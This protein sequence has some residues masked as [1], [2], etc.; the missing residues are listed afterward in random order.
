VSPSKAFIEE[1][2]STLKF[3][4]RAKL[5]RVTPKV[6]EVQD[7]S[8]LIRKLEHELAEARRQLEELAKGAKDF[9]MSS[10]G[11]PPETWQAPTAETDQPG[12]DGD[13]DYGYEDMDAPPKQYVM[14]K[15][16]LVPEENPFIGGGQ[17]NRAYVMPKDPQFR[18]DIPFVAPA[19]PSGPKDRAYVMPKNQSVLPINNNRQ[20]RRGVGKDERFL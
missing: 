8:A 2:R 1:T 13:V 15:D 10:A 19:L 6:N 3:A 17:G 5:V 4:A 18:D 16:S 11:R 20:R 9:K 7:D 14:P 12:D